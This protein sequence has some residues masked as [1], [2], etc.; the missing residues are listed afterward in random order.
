MCQKVPIQHSFQ[1]RS[2]DPCVVLRLTL[3]PL[4]PV[5]DNQSIVLP[6]GLTAPFFVLSLLSGSLFCMFLFPSA[7]LSSS[8]I[9]EFPICTSV[10]VFYTLS[11]SSIKSVSI[12]LRISMKYA[13]IYFLTYHITKIFFMKRMFF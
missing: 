1:S 11:P 3:L 13:L 12:L 7:F 10:L 9:P 2:N 5:L 6:V 4:F 8:L